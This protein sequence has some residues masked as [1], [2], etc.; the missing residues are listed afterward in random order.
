MAGATSS[1]KP[2]W[3]EPHHPPS[4]RGRGHVI[5]RAYVAVAMSTTK[6]TWHEPRHPPSLRESRHPP[7][8]GGRCHVIDEAYVAVAM[9][10]TKPT[11]QCHVIHQAH[12][13]DTVS[14]T[15][16]TW[17]LPRHSQ[18]LHGGLYEAQGAGAQKVNDGQV[19]I[20]RRVEILVRVT[21]RAR[22]LLAVHGVSEVGRRPLLFSNTGDESFAG[23]SFSSGATFFAKVSYRVGEGRRAR[24]LI[25]SWFLVKLVLR[26]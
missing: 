26:F 8:L 21:L 4:L 19:L 14:S 16:V 20:L 13:G 25:A 9:S 2:M 6:P 24:R 15:K 11:W 22:A 12:V 7:S 18:C 23:Q 5:H 17:Q 3:Q 10:S 1:L